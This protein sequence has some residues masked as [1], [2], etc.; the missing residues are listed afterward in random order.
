PLFK[1]PAP[2]PTGCGKLRAGGLVASGC[3]PHRP[4]R[5]PRNPA[6]A[7]AAWGAPRPGRGSILPENSPPRAA[8]AR[9]TPG[10]GVAPL[11][12]LLPARGHGPAGGPDERGIPE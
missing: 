2:G 4:V 9:P 6:A 5:P 10:P 1:V 3:G 11:A 7:V 12:L 8:G